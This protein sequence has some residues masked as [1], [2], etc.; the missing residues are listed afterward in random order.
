MIKKISFLIVV[1][2][3]LSGFDT[4]FFEVD[5]L[6]YYTKVYK[7]EEIISCSTSSTKSYM[8]YK[9]ITNT[10]SK[11]YK[12]IQKYMEVHSSGLLIDEDGFI[13]VAL[14]SYYGNIGDRFYFTLETGVVLPVVKIDAK[15]NVDTDDD[16]CEHNSDSSVLE[17]VID[18]DKALEFF[19]RISNQYI[20]NGNFNNYE[21]FKGKIIKVEKVLKEKKEKRVTYVKGKPKKFN[22]LDI[23]KGGEY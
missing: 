5:N 3:I 1:L 22:N 2:V 10:S 7:T 20:L 16:G 11:Q 9:A 18:Y 21:L 13:G 4:S 17:F 15:A 23:F 12:H 19:G 8:D 14:G 6:T